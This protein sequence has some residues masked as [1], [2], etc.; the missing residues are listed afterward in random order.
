MKTNLT[1]REVIKQLLALDKKHIHLSVLDQPATF[2]DPQDS[3]SHYN[4]TDVV[5]ED[6]GHI[7]FHQR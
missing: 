2:T 6:D 1:Y 7:S 4:I 3:D 5:R